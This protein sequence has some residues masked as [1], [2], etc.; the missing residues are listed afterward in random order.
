[1]EVLPAIAGK[2]VLD[3]ASD[4]GFG[5]RLMSDAGAREVI[6]IDLNPEIVAYAVERY[7]VG[8]PSLAFRKLDIE[9]DIEEFDD[10][11]FRYAVSAPFKCE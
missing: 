10:S 11:Q 3:A 6:G 1:M 4:S 5:S 9:A 7:G 2:R 8:V